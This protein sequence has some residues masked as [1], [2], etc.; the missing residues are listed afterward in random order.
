MSRRCILGS[1][2]LWVAAVILTVLTAMHQRKTG[3]TYPISGTYTIANDEYN[4][5]L[6]RS[7]GGKD[8]QEVRIQAPEGASGYIR[9]WYY[10]TDWPEEDPIKMEWDNGFL[11]GNLPHQPPAGK[12]KYGVVISYGEETVNLPADDQWAITRFKGSVPAWVLIPHII[13]MFAGMLTSN[14]AGFE[15]VFGKKDPKILSAVTLALLFAGGGILGCI[16][17]YYAFG[18]PWTGFPV[19]H[20]L[21]DNKLALAVI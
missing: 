10:P 18:Q 9:W 21:T 19:G 11:V 12:L 20:D 4:F 13:M 5:S 2:V 1:T 6:S 15:I 17:Q 3:P 8:D 7:Q 14:R 16:V